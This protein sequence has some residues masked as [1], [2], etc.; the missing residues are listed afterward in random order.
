MNNRRNTCSIVPLYEEIGKDIFLHEKRK[1]SF[2]LK[3]FENLVYNMS[4]PQLKGEN[5]MK[6]ED[7][8]GIKLS[9]I[10]Q[11]LMTIIMEHAERGS[12]LETD[13][14]EVIDA[15]KEEQNNVDN[16]KSLAYELASKL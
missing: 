12:K 6:T 3:L 1:F 4:R 7:A 16:I 14:I 2:L 13:L 5:H 8:K 11:K 10:T 9:N 15:V